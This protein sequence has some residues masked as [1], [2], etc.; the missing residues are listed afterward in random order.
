MREII[1]GLLLAM[2]L[3]AV[4]PLAHAGTTEENLQRIIQD[5]ID[6]PPETSGDHV[7]GEQMC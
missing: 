6:H 5:L 3:F 7:V 2:A 1:F 4:M